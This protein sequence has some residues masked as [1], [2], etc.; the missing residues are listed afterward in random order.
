MKTI[1]RFLG[2][3]LLMSVFAVAGTTSAFAQDTAA[4][5]AG[6]CE[7]LDAANALY[8]K[9]TENYAN[10]D[11]KVRQIAVD[12]GEEYLKTYGAC[13]NFEAQVNYV[14]GSLDGWKKGI[15]DQIIREK[16]AALFARY[17]PAAK[18]GNWDETYAAGKQIID[19]DPDTALNVIID[20]GS[21]AL[22]EAAKKP[23]VT[24][25]N[26]DSVKY[27]R[28]AI[29]KLEAGKTTKNFG[30]RFQYGS[31]NNAI[32]W[33]NYTIGYVTYFGQNNKKEGLSYIYKATQNEAT[34]N[35]PQVYSV[36]GDYYR[37]EVARL[38]EEIKGKAPGPDGRDT[39]ET[40]ALIA[41]LKA[42][43]ERAIDAYARA[44]NSVDLNKEP[45]L[46]SYKEALGAQVET[47]Y[48]VRFQKVDGLS[49]FV[50]TQLAKPL[51]D[52]TTVPTPIVEVEPEAA[53]A[54]ATTGTPASS[55]GV[56]PGTPGTVK[57]TTAP[58]TNGTKPATAPAPTTKKPVS[59]KGTTTGTTTAVK[60]AVKKPVVKKKGTR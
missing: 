21:V 47:L 42:Y 53:P 45:G 9:V 18:A 25:Y 3:A 49:A 12:S 51:P 11:W 24:K 23:P 26:E 14:K 2:L 48:K 41:Q 39:D 19:M 54:P 46:K 50:N 6:P 40:K 15:A 29:Q 7:S 60:A 13:A 58:A 4:T 20:L 38:G 32:G 37:D 33:L 31:K 55:T 22:V 16:R 44:Q 27:A 28:M 8:A 59:V 57:P 10:K 17:E 43:A 34:K 30:Y 35:L 52:P 36:I 1:F 56:K 5:P